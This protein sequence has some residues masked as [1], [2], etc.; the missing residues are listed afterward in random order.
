MS[1]FWGKPPYGYHVWASFNAS[2]TCFW[3]RSWGLSRQRSKLQIVGIATNK[4]KTHHH[5]STPIKSTTVKYY[6]NRW[7]VSVYHYYCCCR[8]FTMY[9]CALSRDATPSGLPRDCTRR[10]HTAVTRSN[11]SM[12][13]GCCS[14]IGRWNPTFFYFRKHGRL[15]R[16]DLDTWHVMMLRDSTTTNLYVAPHTRSTTRS[17]RW[18]RQEYRMKLIPWNNITIGQKYKVRSAHI[19]AVRCVSRHRK[20]ENR[21]IP[22]RRKTGWL[23]NSTSNNRNEEMKK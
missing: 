13:L 8:V 17:T 11:W 2:T 5:S 15:W 22:T 18:H 16:L 10:V 7:W 23:N 3:G 20:R 6:H 9:V 4:H 1:R 14:T 19:H 21:I 12:F